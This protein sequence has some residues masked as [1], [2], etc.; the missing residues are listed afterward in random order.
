M[1]PLIE[2][3]L[4]AVP[5][6]AL[7][8]FSGGSGSGNGET[9]KKD[10]SGYLVRRAKEGDSSAFEE[11]FHMYQQRLYFSVI[12]IVLN[13][14]D[15]ND[16]VQESFIKAYKNLDTFKEEFRFYTWLYRIAVNTALNFV[17]QSRHKEDSLDGLYSDK[18]FDPKMDQDIDQEVLHS[19]MTHQVKD[20]LEFIPPDMRT[21]FIMRAYEELSYK[22]IAETLDISI[23]T[24]MSRLH[25][26]RSMLKSRLVKTG[27]YQD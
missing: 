11:L 4:A 19:E 24:V 18:R 15:A 21:V 9:R 13:H 26:A 27:W 17:Q 5:V 14:E 3:V 1:V 8:I 23:G 20:A 12:R 10:R 7:G 22:E 2:L 6:I 25:R 16:V